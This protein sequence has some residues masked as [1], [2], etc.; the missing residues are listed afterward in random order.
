MEY[1]R[2]SVKP[3]L[4]ILLIICVMCALFTLTACATQELDAVS[5]EVVSDTL[6]DVATV[7]NF[8]V[9]QLKLKV[10]CADG[11]EPE[12]A[13]TLSML[14]SASKNSL[15]EPGEKTINV[16]YNKRATTFTIL[17]VEEGTETVS[18]TFLAQDG[19]TLAKKSAVKGGSIVAPTAPLVNG[20]FFAVWLNRDTNQKVN[21]SAVENDLVVYASYSENEITYTVEFYDYNGKKIHTETIAHGD[22]IP[23]GPIWVD[24]PDEIATYDWDFD[25][26]HE[27][28]MRDMKIT[29]KPIFEKRNV[30][31]KYG[32]TTDINETKIS[33]PIEAKVTINSTIEDADLNRAKAELSNLKQVFIRWLNLQDVNEGRQNTLIALVETREYTIEFTDGTNDA[34]VK[35]GQLYTMPTPASQ[36]GYTVEGWKDNQGNTYTVGTAYPIDDDITLEP[37]Y[38]AEIQAVTFEFKF[39]GLSD[40]TDPGKTLSMKTEPPLYYGYVVKRDYVESLLKDLKLAITDI[41]KKDIE[42]YDIDIIKYGETTVSSA[43][44][45]LGLETNHTFTITC[46]DISLGSPGLV[47]Q[48]KNANDASDGYIV[49]G[50]T[51]TDINSEL[52]IT[53]PEMHEGQP[54]VGIAGGV[55]SV[56]TQGASLNMFITLPE[57]LLSIGERAFEGV[58]FL[59]NITIRNSLK[60]LG[61]Y[62]FNEAYS[63]NG[64]TVTFEDGENTEFTAIPSNAFS[65]FVGLEEV[66]LS[67][68][69]ISIADEAFYGCENLQKINLDNVTELGSAAFANCVSLVDIGSTDN[70]TSIS[71]YALGATGLISI[72]LPNL[73]NLSPLSLIYNEKL[74]TLIIGTGTNIQELTFDFANLMGSA[75]VK[76]TLGAK[77]TAI[78]NTISENYDKIDASSED[79]IYAMSRLT[80]INFPKELLNIDVAAFNMFPLVKKITVAADSAYY[81]QDNALFLGESLVCYPPFVYGDYTVPMTV[82]DV[83]I[84]TIS[85]NAFKTVSLN[86][87]VLQSNITTVL[88][89]QIASINV[90]EMPLSVLEALY[91]APVVLSETV[92]VANILTVLGQKFKADV[93]YFINDYATLNVQD[94][95]KVDD[96]VADETKAIV[97]QSDEITSYYDAAYKLLYTINSDKSDK[98]V[99]II[100]GDRAATWIT[101]PPTLGGHPVRYIA[102]GAFSGYDFLEKLTIETTLA[103]LEMVDTFASCTS[104]AEITLSGLISNKNI[105]Y[106]LFNDTKLY[107]ESVII[108]LAGVPVAYNANYSVTETI[109]ETEITTTITEVTASDLA[110]ATVIP[111]KFFSGKS[112]LTKITLPDSVILIKDYAFEDCQGLTSISLNKVSSVGQYVFKG[113]TNLIDVNIP[114]LGKIP[115][116]MFYECSSLVTV[117]MTQVNGFMANTSGESFAFFGC[118]SLKDVSFLSRFTGIIYAY[119]FSGCGIEVL[120]ISNATIT[121]IRA[122]AF[123]GCDDLSYLVLGNVNVI[124]ENAFSQSSNALQT[125]RIKGTGGIF[126]QEKS[127]GNIISEGV[128]PP[129]VIIYIDAGVDEKDAEYFL[130]DYYEYRIIEPRISYEM[131]TGFSAGSNQL[132]IPAISISYIAT[133]PSAP[134]FAGYVFANWFTYDNVEYSKAVFPMTF[135]EDT[136]LYAKYYSTSQGSLS[137]NDLALLEDGTYI[138]DTYASSD[139][140][141]YIPDKYVDGNNTYTI[142]QINLSAFVGKQVT[143]LEIPEGVTKLTGTLMGSVVTKIKIASTVTEISDSAFTNMSNLDIEW[144][145]NSNLIKASVNAFSNTKWFDYEDG[146]AEKGFN[147]RFV[148][149][150]RLAIYY[151]ESTDADTNKIIKIPSNVI[152][153]NDDLFRNKTYITTVTLNNGLQVIG[154][155]CFNGAQNL[156]TVN[157]ETVASASQITYVPLNAFMDTKVMS[158]RNEVIIGTVFLKYNGL[159]AVDTY[160][161]PE[162][163]TKISAEAFSQASLKTIIF[164]GNKVATIEYR[165]FYD[166]DLTSITLPSSI[167]VIGEGIFQECKDLLT[168]NLSNATIGELKKDTFNGCSELKT[169]NL[170]NAV[171]KFEAGSLTSCNKLVN[172]TANGL[173]DTSGLYLS[174]LYATP[175]YYGSDEEHLMLGKVYIKYNNTDST[176]II[177]PAGI[178]II[179]QGAFSEISTITKVTIPS[180]VKTIEANAFFQCTSLKEVIFSGISILEKI[181]ENAFSGANKL[182]TIT[183]PE[184]L[185][186]IGKRAFYQTSFRSII[187]PDSVTTIDDYAFEDCDKLESII[188]GKGLSY[189]GEGA[190]RNNPNIYKVEWALESVMIDDKATIQQFYNID[191]ESREKDYVLDG[192]FID[193]I[194]SRIDTNKIR[195]YVPNEAVALIGG[196]APTYVQLWKGRANF[197]FTF[198][199][200]LP[201]VVFDRDG[202]IMPNLSTELIESLDKPSKTNHTFKYWQVEGEEEPMSFPY[203]VKRDIT[204]NAVWYNNIRTDG[205]SDE[206]L[207]YA[208]NVDGNDQAVSYRITSI[209]AGNSVMYVPNKYRINVL[210]AGLPL[211]GFDL[212]VGTA[213]EVT[214]IIFTQASNFYGI[215]TN[216][217]KVFTN[218]ESVEILDSNT[219]NVNYKIENGAMSSIDG[220]VLI[221]YFI[222]RDSLGNAITHFDVPND[223]TTILPYAF[224]NSQLTSVYIPS[225]VTTI[226]EFAFNDDITTIDFGSEIYLT[227]A[228]KDSFVNTTWYAE[229]SLQDNLV[230][231]S[232]VGTFYAAGNML[233]NY[234]EESESNALQLPNSVNGYNI[235]V[236]ASEISDN[237]TSENPRPIAYSKITLPSA[238]KKINAAAFA[239]LNTL[240]I[241][242]S[243]CATTLV[244]IANNVFEHTDYYKT[245]KDEG[246]LILGKVLVRYTNTVSELDLRN[247]PITTIANKALM[248]AQFTKIWLPT[249][250]TYISDNAFY[251]SDRLGS[252]EIPANVLS[253]GASAFENCKELSQITFNANSQMVEIGESAFQNCFIL[254]R[255]AVPYTV[256]TIG[257]NAFNN[258]LKLETVTFN[259]EVITETGTEITKSRLASLGSGAFESCSSLTAIS[260]PNDLTEIKANTFKDCTK[261]VNVTFETN[262]SKVKTIGIQAFYGCTSLGNRIDITNPNL[263]TLALPN[264]LVS[265]ERE[266]FAYS[267]GLYGIRFN[268]NIRTIGERVFWG[269]K[270]LTKIEM[271]ADTPPEIASNALTRETQDPND[272][273][274]YN[275]RIYVKNSPLNYVYNKYIDDWSAYESN[276]FTMKDYA[277]LTYRYPL[278]EDPDEQEPVSNL[279]D[280]YINPS[281]TFSNKVVVAN[282]T[283]AT[284]QD[285]ESTLARAGTE[286]GLANYQKQYNPLTAANDIILVIDGDIVLEAVIS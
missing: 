97:S 278:S 210:D 253:I 31:F 249:T 198:M 40:E 283:F 61:Q 162:Y 204:I 9:S 126:A 229:S 226:G 245:T 53:V 107:K 213:D 32:Y 211:V 202:Y 189:I 235:T 6:P 59:G 183:F 225:S 28:I 220:K 75:V 185:K 270:T 108:V 158:T 166:S 176:E 112:N 281:H 69:I 52:N 186:V 246:L 26:M 139:E 145:E 255:I 215:N 93:V 228:T 81:V 11:S 208:P 193:T 95:E 99:T 143:Y 157:Y 257:D 71:E 161:I 102:D 120:D 88:A 30:Y 29:M 85:A 285:T 47:Y 80:E 170:N 242:G 39:E 265:V 140:A 178:L 164:N 45:R 196:D 168:A 171:A 261:L 46:V 134:V 227:D 279:K 35:A 147:G 239:G 119:A 110:G 49:N 129:N 169:L 70:I 130:P 282:W 136:V 94:K 275:L 205:M 56:T 50:Y 137:N 123:L 155:N 65:S 13:V 124:G 144:A 206:I 83:D 218:L 232:P 96:L 268:Y 37:I 209:A 141:C 200:N 103:N 22:Y 42:K 113:C 10:I 18:V 152:K 201:K 175:W 153:L 60:T 263:V 82:N 156:V 230:G 181:D 89:T 217:F 254:G 191:V 167:K 5:I 269:C 259:K 125:V 78:A 188:L 101:I 115:V 267:S 221:A 128:F 16:F 214:K 36:T 114:N 33:L 179:A 90:V 252:I 79:D 92:T 127:E 212:G 271:Y 192:A 133:A 131:M 63:E 247:Y 76:L 207:D 272:L 148:V 41:E 250:L 280:V 44:Q 122:N 2:V 98:I 121:E 277:K 19:T 48:L 57:G 160:N 77:V 159:R 236:I 43:G 132:E 258:C 111:F 203:S 251:G 87:L 106:D 38:V 190:F 182:D 104:L 149:A 174:G 4:S 237:Y 234:D 284:V 1:K 12:I 17:L 219:Q 72:T 199:G 177:I 67:T 21:F 151:N 262:N 184:S 74:T 238:L 20:K 54:V 62:A 224:V 256:K 142:S 15:K 273:P 73:A 266:A 173:S 233:L 187:I 135:T 222:Q 274:Y 84:T 118:T 117:K 64:I 260:I 25:F 109:G 276:I 27:P 51:P 194:F 116:G 86:K 3:M 7:G 197:E 244:D 58:N 241:D 34:K 55:F 150:G 165:A 138:L 66:I 91:G 154:E 100:G 195:M 163:I 14:D 172:I 223:V 105:N 231:G 24:Q 264:A 216:I 240:D 180:S 286:L 146:E 68:S 8:D 243:A 23:R 248:A